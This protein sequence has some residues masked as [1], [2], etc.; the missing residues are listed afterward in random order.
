MTARKIHAPACERNREPIVEVLRSVDGFRGDVLEIA[1]G[2]GMHAL[3]FTMALPEVRW[4]PTDA[5]DG[6]LASIAAW[7]EDDDTG[8]LLEPIRLDVLSRPWPVGR[9]DALFNAN[10]IH[11]SPWA[12]TRGLFAGAAEILAEGAPLVLYGPYRI[13]GERWAES[14]ERFDESLRGRDPSWG[15]RALADVCEVAAEAGFELERRVPMPAENQTLVFRRVR[16]A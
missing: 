14:N 12:C 8:R 3:F 4:Q 1:S 16:V 5:D 9:A 11:I 15:V 6:A 2:T 13:D 7:R 10:M